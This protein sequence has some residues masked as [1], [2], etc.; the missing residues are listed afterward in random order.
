MNSAIFF[1]HIT[2]NELNKKILKSFEEKAK[3]IELKIEKCEE[4]I[5]ELIKLC[6]LLLPMLVNGQDRVERGKRKDEKH[7][8]I[9]CCI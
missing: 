7:N 6:D 3:A 1:N 5:R 2:P 9:I 4:E 8:K